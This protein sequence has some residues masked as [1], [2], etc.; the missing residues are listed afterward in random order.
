LSKWQNEK[1]LVLETAQRLS[2]R[3]MVIGTSGNVSLRLPPENGRELLAITPT[4]RYYDQLT[5]D[6]IQVI[7]FEVEPVEGDLP[8]SSESLLHIGVYRAR[9]DVGAVIHTHSVYASAMA[10]AHQGIPP[11]L[12]DQVTVIGGEISLAEYAPSGSEEL[13]QN[14]LRALE[15]RNAVLLMNHGMLGAGRDLREALTVCELVEKT[16]HVFYLNMSLGKIHLLPD[17][18]IISGQSFFKMLHSKGQED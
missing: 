17:E 16:A 8:P 11:I 2:E 12:E 5:P 14:A 18:A 1:K 6:D 9:N 3:G 10:V 7:D 13:V 4:S 15:K